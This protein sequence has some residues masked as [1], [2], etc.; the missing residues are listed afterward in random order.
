MAVESA[1]PDGWGITTVLWNQTPPEMRAI[2]LAMDQRIKTQAKEIADLLGRV[3]HLEARLN[4]NS[5]NSSKPPSSD[6]PSVQRRK[7]SRS[8]KKRG[9]QPEH[10]GHHRPLVDNPDHVIDH[11][12][13][14][15]DQCGCGLDGTASDPNPIR[16]Q[17]SEIPEPRVVVTEHRFHRATCDSCKQTMPAPMPPEV[18]QSAFGPRLESTVAILAGRFRLSHREIQSCLLQQNHLTLGLGSIPAILRRVSEA[19]AGPTESAWEEVRAADVRYVDETGWKESNRKSWLWVAVSRKATAFRVAATRGSVE[20]KEC[21][22]VSLEQGVIVSDRCRSYK[23]VAIKRRGICHAH[24]KRD[25]TKMTELGH[26]LAVEV[27]NA[28]LAIHES[29]FK[30]FNRFRAGELTR[31]QLVQR[32]QRHQ[33][34][35]RKVLKRGQAAKAPPKLRGMCRDILEHEPAIWTFVTTPDVEPTNNAAERA[36]R[37]AVLWRK[38]SFGTQSKAGSRFV[39]R[40][41]TVA[42]TCVQQGLHVAHYVEEAVNAARRKLAPPALIVS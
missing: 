9:G 21:F 5:T 2:V 39:E 17:V 41:L 10:P 42:Q 1:P 18:V 32:M 16:H 8:G 37:K 12:A 4:T 15:C 3:V 26:P 31:E 13:E 20:L 23:V 33:Y 40:I 22:G 36:V 30:L 11:V 7:A 35:L 34:A 6:P 24:L 27:G 25:Y 28:A 14:K 29:V 38:G 19:L